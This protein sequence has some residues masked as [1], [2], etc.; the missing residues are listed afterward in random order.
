SAA[1]LWVGSNGGHRILWVVEAYPLMFD[2]GISGDGYNSQFPQWGSV[3]QVVRNYDVIAPRI[4][5]IIARRAAE[6]S[7]DPFKE[8]L[9]P[10]L[11]KAQLTALRKIYDIPMKLTNGFRQNDGRWFG[12]EAN[13]KSNYNALLG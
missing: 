4:D 9:S 11:T 8:P 13:W 10:P 7:W 3:A 1:V 2:G 12:S 5:D 6:P